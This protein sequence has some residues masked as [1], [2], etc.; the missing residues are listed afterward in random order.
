MPKLSTSHGLYLSDDSSDPTSSTLVSSSGL[1]NDLYTD[2]PHSYAVAHNS[3][4]LDFGSE[5]VFNKLVLYSLVRG[6]GNLYATWDKMDVYTSSD[7][8]SW[9]LIEEF[10]GATDCTVI[11][12]TSHCHWFIQLEEFT[13]ARY[14]KIYTPEGLAFSS[15]GVSSK[16]SELEAFCL[17]Y[18][19][20]ASDYTVLNIDCSKI[21]SVLTDFPVII[22]L[23]VWG[24]TIGDDLSDSDKLKMSAGDVSGSVQYYI[25]IECWE[26]NNHT[27]H[28]RVPSISSSTR[29]ESLI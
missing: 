28:V 10:E 3:Y 8:A 26:I 24:G 11:D 6:S 23:D 9:A 16:I 29:D 5:K 27:I 21:D 15:G 13:T 19:P 2:E 20:A 14:V 1:I 25:E 4:G 12:E 18:P 7:N 17:F 22:D